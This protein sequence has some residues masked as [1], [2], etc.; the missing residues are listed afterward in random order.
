MGVGHVGGIASQ[1]HTPHPVRLSGPLMHP[2]V[3]PQDDLVIE[4]F[5]RDDGAE[6]VRHPL[7]D[8]LLGQVQRLGVGVAPQPVRRDLVA[9]EVLED[10]TT[11]GVLPEDQAVG[12]ADIVLEQADVHRDPLS[13]PEH[14]GAPVALEVPDGCGV[15]QNAQP[16]KAGKCRPVVCHAA[17][18]IDEAVLS[19]EDCHRH[20]RL[21]QAE[22]SD[23]TDRPGT[24]IRSSPWN[25]PAPAPS[26]RQAVVASATSKSPAD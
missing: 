4:A 13:G 7:L 3:P 15:S 14:L 23:E 17:G 6:V 9:L 2:V 24:T 26:P 20:P 12:V 11:E 21:R 22:R 16:L 25:A 5:R 10:H 18:L 1:Q 19:I 8:A